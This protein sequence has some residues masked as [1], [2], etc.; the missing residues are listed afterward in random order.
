MIPYRTYLLEVKE[1][2]RAVDALQA[3][4]DKH[5]PNAEE[6]QR[7]SG[8]VLP[9]NSIFSDYKKK[10]PFG[11]DEVRKALHLSPDTPMQGR[12]IDPATVVQDVPTK[13]LIA[14]QPTLNANTVRRKLAIP[15]SEWD[16]KDMPLFV[17]YKGKLYVFDGHHRCAAGLLIGMN[18]MVGQVVEL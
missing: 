10:L 15:P 18:K 5:D 17:Q 7:P 6:T 14:S 4:V 8:P 2:D 13:A 11:W 9:S 1:L 16:D 12:P 3:L